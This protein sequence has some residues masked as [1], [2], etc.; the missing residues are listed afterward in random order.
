MNRD[1]D[2]YEQAD[3]AAEAQPYVIIL[4]NEKGGTGKSTTAVHLIVALLRLEFSVGCIDLDGRQATLSRYFDKRRA[5]AERR[6]R[7]LPM[8]L[9]RRVERSKA[10]IQAA[11]EAEEQNRFTEALDAMTGCDFVVIDTPG[12]DSF[13]SRLG[14]AYADTLI[15]PLNDSFLDLDVLAEVDVERRE[16]RNPSTYTRMVWEQNNRRVV[17]GREP[18]DWLVLRNRLSHVEARNKRD[19]AALMERLAQR[20]GFRLSP[21]FGERVVFRELFHKGLTVLDLEHEPETAAPTSSHLAA[22]AEIDDLLEAIGV[23]EPEAE[24]PVPAAEPSEEIAVAQ[25]GA[26]AGR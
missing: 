12:S 15:T 7:A 24:T 2:G 10:P 25:A 8:P 5:Y 4:G 3:T 14:H 17:T 16:A 19:I 22:R 26:V 6:S 11:A 1:M 20:I 18:I 13:L 21:G 9:H 23:Y